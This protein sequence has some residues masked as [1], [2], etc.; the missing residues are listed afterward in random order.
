M[1]KTTVLILAIIAVALMLYAGVNALTN[2]YSYGPFMIFIGVCS[3]VGLT[4]DVF[5]HIQ[6]SL[7]KSNVRK[8]GRF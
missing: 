3:A 7:R 6:L 1:K 4:I 8:L 2:D 5:N